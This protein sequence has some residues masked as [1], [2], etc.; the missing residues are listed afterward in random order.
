MPVPA[1]P[2]PGAGRGRWLIA[3]GVAG[4]AVAAI[5]AGVLLLGGRQT[6]EALRYVPADAL[7]V[8]ELRLELPGDQL[9]NVGNLLAHF[10]GFADQST[11]AL[12][13]DEAGD[14]ILGALSAGE[15]RYTTDLKP[16]VAG[17]AFAA[18]RG[19]EAGATATG[20]ARGLVVATTNGAVG[21]DAVLEDR[22][23]TTETHRGLE[24]RILAGGLGACVVDGRFVLLGDPASVRAGLDAHAEDRGVETTERYRTARA[25]LGGD[26]LAT[27]FVSGEAAALATDLPGMPPL[28]PTGLEGASLPDWSIVGIRAEDDALVVDALTAPLPAP[29]A[30][31]SLLSLAPAHP[32]E[33]AR[34]V[35]RSAMTYA[36]V[37][38]AGPTIV[39]A[40]RVL[41]ADP[42]LGE[43]LGEL[44]QVL[45]AFGGAEQ[46]IGWVEDAA[47]VVLND[48]GDMVGDLA[49]G[50][51]LLAPDEATAEARLAS[52]RS[53][54]AL[55][56]LSGELELRT[57]TINGLEV[58]TVVLAGLSELPGEG[59]VEISFALAGRMVVVGTSEAF[60]TMTLGLGEQDSLAR[61]PG[62]DAHGRGLPDPRT[63]VYLGVEQAVLFI[64]ESLSPDERARFRSEVALYLAPIE[65]IHMSATDG[66]EGSRARIVMTVTKPQQP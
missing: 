2:V 46:L 51:L 57:S 17:P 9:Q 3:I 1:T 42:A 54:L 30:L 62:L 5:V 12:K 47:V 40:L 64:A 55:A 39:N 8:A 37:Q 7:I 43:T 38:G 36:E 13:L 60:M 26:Q 15:L 10:P 52:Y 66:P 41:R 61:A 65:S 49:G 20:R 31:P 63:M 24:L 16:W 21:C 11:L 25:A 35:P 29:S 23:T 45:T 32:S 48:G 28:G 59:A 6:P 34:H 4:V 14:R 22:P 33:L 53:L 18:L 19:L 50:V 27:L 44:D 58:T 56:A